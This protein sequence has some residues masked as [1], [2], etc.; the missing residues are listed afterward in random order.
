MTDVHNTDLPI[1]EVL[2][3]LCAVFENRDTVILEAP[4]G[5]GKTSIVPLALLSAKWLTERRIIVLQPRRI[6]TRNA[7][8]RMASLLGE[9]VGER[10]GYRMRQ[11]TRVSGAT[12]IEVVTEG[13]LLR[14]LREDPS[15]ADVGLIIFDEFHERSLDADLGL[16]L[17]L[18]ARQTF[19][20]DATFRVLIMSATLQGLALEDLLDAPV[21]SSAGRAFPVETVYGSASAPRERIIDKVIPVIERA[22]TKHPES[23]CLVFLP[24][25]GE[26]RQVAARL[27]LPNEVDVH[28]LYGNLSMSEQQY[29]I[30]PSPSGRRKVVLATNIAETS[31]TIEGVD[32]VID[33][34]LQRVPVYDPNTGMT[35]LQTAKISQASSE[36]RQGRAGRLQPGICYRLWSAAQQSQL[37]QQALPEIANADLSTLALQLYSWGTAEPQ[38]LQWLTPPP[39]GAYQQ[40][41]ALLQSLGALSTM[42]GSLSLTQ[43]GM[44]MAELTMHP[45][46]AHML[47]CGQRAGATET[48]S[49]LAAVLSERDPMQ[50]ESYEMQDRLEC[51]QEPR[52]APSTLRGWK[53][54]TT[55]LAKQFRKQ[56]PQTSNSIAVLVPGDQLIAYLLACAYPDRIAR[57]RNSGGYQLA[58]GR[59]AKFDQ[60]SQLD[61]EKWLAIAE[62]SGRAGNS[63]DLI[64]S[65]T[66]LNVALFEGPLRDALTETV[67]TEWD[68]KTGAFIGERQTRCGVLLFARQRLDTL[69]DELRVAGLLEL[70]R[71]GQLKQLPWNEGGERYLQRNQLMQQLDTD[72]PAFDNESL[73]QTAEAWL[74]PYLSVVTKLSA[75]KKLDLTDMLAARLSWDQRQR[76][77]EWLPERLTVP[78]GSSIRVDYTKTPPVLAVKLQEMFGCVDTPLLAKGKLPVVVHLLSPA[79]RPLQITQDLAG[80]WASSYE[81]VKKDM[82]GR[83]PK[84]PWPE[85]PLSATA[86]RYTKRRSKS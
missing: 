81:A 27:N 73:S 22:I 19:P 84:H 24:G 12:R 32:V 42:G 28:P 21:V 51:L 65:A 67:V 74:A 43:H 70:L 39:D 86:T 75:L 26:I 46:L 53:A 9:T 82:K 23:S 85:D 38:A 57:R 40:A 61:K 31:L 11:D 69:S 44:R 48:V 33:S 56:L 5:A 71:E 14:M 64:R 83:Y 17:A 79:G 62:V 63:S 1:G 34:G 58:N 15:L 49:F 13:I 7:A 77:D 36:Q 3:E 41:Q 4:P 59:S 10:V 35:R 55:Q 6:A 68:K 18:N 30:S 20:D 76:L 45:R 47:L 66:A 60:A 50:R 8:Q 16:A 80:F 72:W 52:A 2:E 37:E 25:E 29:A 78:S 54:R